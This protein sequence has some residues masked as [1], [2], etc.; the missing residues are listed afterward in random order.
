MFKLRLDRICQA[1]YSHLKHNVVVINFNPLGDPSD[2]EE[3]L[4]LVKLDAGH[5]GAVVEHV[6]GVG[7]GGQGTDTV[8][9]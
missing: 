3:L 9:P 7:Q 1:L 8:V 2:G 4:V 6:R 5:D